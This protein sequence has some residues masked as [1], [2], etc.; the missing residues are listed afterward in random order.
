M[1]KKRTHSSSRKMRIRCHKLTRKRV[2]DC[3]RIGRGLPTHCQRVKAQQPQSVRV[4][5]PR[6]CASDGSG[7][8][9]SHLATEPMSSGPVNQPERAED[10]ESVIGDEPSRGPHRGSSSGR[11]QQQA[12]IRDGWSE[13]KRVAEPN[14][15]PVG[16]VF[17][18]LPWADCNPTNH[19]RLS[20]VC[21]PQC[22]L[23]AIK[24]SRITH[25]FRWS[26]IFSK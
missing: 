21:A 22:C 12:T 6:S 13:A 23:G 3:N 9:I 1:Y 16:T 19:L 4:S 25:Y 24:R 7:S 17:R 10:E 8:A 14:Q 5:H 20:P 15:Q 11:K 2:I 26:F 18:R